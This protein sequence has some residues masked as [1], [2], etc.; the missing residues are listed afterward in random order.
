MHIAL[1]FGIQ[2]YT[3]TGTGASPA[4]IGAL[5][6]LYDVTRLYPGQESSS[7]T[8]EAWASLPSDILNSGKVPL[9][10][11]E[12]GSASIS[13][14]FPE[15]KALRVESLHRNIPYLG[16]HFFNANGVPIFDLHKANQRLNAEKVQGIKA[17]ASAPRGP[18][19]T[20]AVD[21]LYLRDAGGSQGISTAYRVLTAGGASHGCAVRGTDSTSYT[22]FYW[23]YG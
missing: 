11:V 2:N 23:F 6:V 9:N 4:A 8:P 22:T 10:S 1:G 20:G 19:G 15:K 14:P 3:C 5:A 13:D 12:D 17:P 16:H 18:E 21:W 7:L